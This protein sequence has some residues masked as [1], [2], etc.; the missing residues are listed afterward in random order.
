MFVIITTLLLINYRMSLKETETYLEKIIN[1][2]KQEI[3]LNCDSEVYGEF[4]LY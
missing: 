2:A 3:L 4:S 1:D